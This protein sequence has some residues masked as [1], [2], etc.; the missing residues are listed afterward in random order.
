[1]IYVITALKA[2]AQAFVE[3][4]KLTEYKN[5]NISVLISGIGKENMYKTTLEVLKSF[6]DEDKIINV[7]ICAADKRFAIGQLIDAR[8]EPITCVDEAIDCRNSE[9][10][11]S[12]V[13]MES[14]GFIEATQGL[15]NSFIFK[16]VSDHFQP[17]TVTKEGAKKLIF[18][19]IDTI[20]KEIKT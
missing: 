5:E 17:N 2:E 7:G 16:V 3:K 8:E 19:N 6:K 13:D 14:R 1:M 12:V 20:M 18:S 10:Q 15:K 4:F 9:N 11:F